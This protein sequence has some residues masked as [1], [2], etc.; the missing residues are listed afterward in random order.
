MT[1]HTDA[2]GA[3]SSHC[4]RE[5]ENHLAALASGHF[6]GYALC[7][8]NSRALRR[9]WLHSRLQSL[10]LGQSHRTPNLASIYHCFIGRF[11]FVC[12][13]SSHYPL[14]SLQNSTGRSTASNERYKPGLRH[15]LLPMLTCHRSNIAEGALGL[16][17]GGKGARV[18]HRPGRPR[19]R[20]RRTRRHRKRNGVHG[21][22]GATDETLGR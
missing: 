5:M 16:R 8:T 21:K 10:D 20:G 17:D 15:C 7:R 3:A 4:G 19:L 14:D 2:F 9:I 13:F 11:A 22:Q 1:N 18:V 12:S 6:S